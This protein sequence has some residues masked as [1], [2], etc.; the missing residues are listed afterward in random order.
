MAVLRGIDLPRPLDSRL[1]HA[2]GVLGSVYQ[3]SSEF[4]TVADTVIAEGGGQIRIAPNDDSPAYTDVL[5]RII[6]IAPGTLAN[7]GSGDGP[8]LVSALTVELNNLSRAQSANEVAWL[9]DQGGMNARSFAQEYERIEYDSAQSHA[10]VFRQAYSALEQHGEAN[11]PDRW[12][13]ERNEQGGFE[14]AFSSFEDYL[15]VQRETG[16]TDVYEDRFR[17]TYNR[18]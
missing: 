3:Q 5:N 18:D 17:Q 2:M 7:S 9:A 8:S 15:G 14:A 6:Y 4:R 13:S 16:H 12:F 10:E 11:N 1:T